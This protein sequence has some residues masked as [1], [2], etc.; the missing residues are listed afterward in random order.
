[1]EPKEASSARGNYVR[2]GKNADVIYNEAD[3]IGRGQFGIVYRGLIPASGTVVAVKLLQNVPMVFTPT[4]EHAGQHSRHADRHEGKDSRPAALSS[5]GPSSSSFAPPAKPKSPGCPSE[6]A[7]LYDVRADNCPN[8]VHVISTWNKVLKPPRREASSAA[9]TAGTSLLSSPSSGE[10]RPSRIFVMVTEYCEGGDLQ[11]FMKARGGALPANVARSFTYQLCNALLTLKRRRIV[12]RDVKP[13]NLLLTSADCEVATLKLADFGMAKAAPAPESHKAG[14]ASAGGGKD[15]GR[16]AR[17]EKNEP[18]DAFSPVFHSEMG[19]PMYMSPERL[20]LQPYGY[21]ADVYS[22]GMVL[23]EMMRGSC[24]QVKWES[25]LRSEVPRTIWR[26]LRQYPPDEVPAWLD[27]VQRMTA[28]DPAQRYSVE[29]VLRHSW[30]H[31]KVGPP[32]PP[33]TFPLPEI[34]EGGGARQPQETRGQGAATPAAGCTGSGSQSTA[35]AEADSLTSAA[36]GAP[37][38]GGDA[39]APGAPHRHTDPT[40]GAGRKGTSVPEPSAYSSSDDGEAGEGTQQAIKAAASSKKHRKSRPAEP[41]RWMVLGVCAEVDAVHNVASGAYAGPPKPA[42]GAEGVSPLA[43]TVPSAVATEAFSLPPGCGPHVITNAVRSFVD[44]V[45]LYVLQDELNAARGL[46]LVSYLME[47]LQNGYAAYLKCLES[48]GCSWRHTTAMNSCTLGGHR[49]VV[50]EVNALYCVWRQLMTRL[51]GA[52]VAYTARLSSCILDSAAAWRQRLLG[53]LATTGDEAAGVDEDEGAPD[54]EAVEEPRDLDVSD[55]SA[56][57]EGE[58]MMSALP[59]VTSISNVVADAEAAEGAGV[60]LLAA[61]P[62]PRI[63]E[64]LRVSSV[65]ARAEQ[66][67]FEKAVECVQSEALSMLMDSPPPVADDLDAM[68]CLEE[69]EATVRVHR[70][71][72]TTSPPPTSERLSTAADHSMPPHRGVALLRVL[73]R[74]AVLTISEVGLEEEGPRSARMPAPGLSPVVAAAAESLSYPVPPPP[75]NPMSVAADS[76]SAD[77][78]SKVVFVVKVPVFGTLDRTDRRTV[79]NLL[80]AAT[81]VISSALSSMS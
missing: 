35:Q 49:L 81:R 64:R 24:V 30:F 44:V 53:A 3:V 58:M 63:A 38:T 43:T 42:L 2:L 80:H 48:L 9:S 12:H 74:R 79:E 39:T 40:V 50:R 37:G 36:V 10:S 27:L 5:A 41:S 21:K 47:L 32:L 62:A 8:I 52:Q 46:T 68:D 11:Q 69:E 78:V 57:S 6:L 55:A 34:S 19:T 28:A 75:L 67:I 77:T 59:S 56:S 14:P 60:P 66:L 73:L 29:D 15:T 45:Y 7:I 65:C 54:A 16:E 26:E 71:R 4:S 22:A 1:M 18:A 23:L 61:P 51:H 31:A 76:V 70:N 33:L 20:A 25:Q 17:N 13:A 72:T